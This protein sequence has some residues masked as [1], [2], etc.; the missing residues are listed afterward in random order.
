MG[1]FNDVKVLLRTELLGDRP[2][3]LGILGTGAFNIQS[4]WNSP[5]F[6]IIPGISGMLRRHLQGSGGIT[7]EI[8]KPWRNL[9]KK[10]P[11]GKK[12]TLWE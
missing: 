4:M 7:K 9:N 2:P 10:I 8:A 1:K 11:I 3:L 5:P 12:K 6:R